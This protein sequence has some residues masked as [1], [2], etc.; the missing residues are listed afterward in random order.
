LN[1]SGGPVF[2]FAW[3]NHYAFDTRFARSDFVTTAMRWRRNRRAFS[4]WG[5]NLDCRFRR[6]FSLFGSRDFNRL[7][8]FD[9]LRR[10]V[11]NALTCG[12]DVRLFNRG[13]DV[14]R[15]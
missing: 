9:G 14:L 1:F 2:S 3:A 11:P 15:R 8:L 10:N 6:R 12:F 13:G 7:D 5:A 4:C